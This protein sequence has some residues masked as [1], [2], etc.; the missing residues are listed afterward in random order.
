MQILHRFPCVTCFRVIVSKQQEFFKRVQ[1]VQVFNV[2]VWWAAW[3]GLISN[4]YFYTLRF[5]QG[6]K[7]NRSTINSNVQVQNRN[8]IRIMQFF[9][10][11]FVNSVLIELWHYQDDFISLLKT[12]HCQQ[13]EY[14]YNKDVNFI[15]LL[16]RLPGTVATRFNVGGLKKL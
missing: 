14:Y 12:I 11:D 4:S 7:L 10:S 2:A 9:K 8:L 15:K 13:Y 6:T 3:I 1:N 16:S 5:F